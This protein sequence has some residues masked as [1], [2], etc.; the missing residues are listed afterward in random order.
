MRDVERTL[1]NMGE[2]NC[3]D[4]LELSHGFN[5]GNYANAYTTE[6]YDQ[7]QD[8]LNGRTGFFRVGCLLGFFA[9]YE[10]HEIPDD[11]RDEVEHY[12]AVARK[13]GLGYVD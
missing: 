8:D 13:L 4:K 1:E 12:R 11:W 2:L 9:S 10:A 3:T 7:M 5:H 6:D